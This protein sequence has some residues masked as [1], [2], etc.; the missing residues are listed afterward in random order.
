MSPKKLFVNIHKI[1]KYA[2]EKQT[3]TIQEQVDSGELSL[4]TNRTEI[5]FKGHILN[6]VATFLRHDEKQGYIFVD[7]YGELKIIKSLDD[8]NIRYFQKLKK[9]A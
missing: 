6:S 1:I 7:Y 2:V 3:K 5:V 9:E 4:Q 8:P